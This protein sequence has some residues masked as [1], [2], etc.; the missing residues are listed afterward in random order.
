[1]AIK[2]YASRC[3]EL[4]VSGSIST[5][6]SYYPNQAHTTSITSLSLKGA[7]HTFS[8]QTAG[9]RQN[10]SRNNMPS[11]HPRIAIIGG[12]PAGLTLGGLLHRQKIPFT[13]YE[14]R[15]RP[16]EA[17]LSEPS[18]MLDLHEE[19]GLAAIRACGLYEQFL[20]YTADCEESTMI[21][22][23]AGRLLHEDKGDL[24]SRP[25]I[26]RNNISRLFLSVLPEEG[27]R[28]IRYGH[29]L[30]SAARDDATGEIALEFSNAD[31]NTVT[32]TCDLV[33]GAD[34]AWSRIRP[35]LTP[36][37][38]DLT[39][40]SYLQLYVKHI[41]A[42]HPAISERVG[43]GTMMALGN[44]HGLGTQRG[45]QDAMQMY[46][47]VNAA[48][49]GPQAIEALKGMSILEQK[50][51]L[52]GDAKF[53]GGYGEPMKELLRIAFDA[54]HAAKSGE[55][56][57]GG[58]LE[59]RPLVMLPVGHAWAH[60]SG[61]TLIGDAA[62]VMLPF[63]GEGVNLAM[64]D[65]LELSQAIVQAAASSQHKED[66]NAALGPLVQDFEREMFARAAQFSKESLD[67]MELHMAEDGAER[68]ATIMKTI[69]ESW[70][71]GPGSDGPPAS[72]SLVDMYEK[73][74][75]N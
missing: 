44:R 22:D 49:A 56:H 31:G 18:A 5:L 67:N 36:A 68:F 74:K 43:K 30:L 54:E 12:G 1:M 23:G 46:V 26:A 20:P 70:G 55:Q 8:I 28:A 51:R 69:Y 62:H 61:V 24:A 75:A 58:T 19:S 41:T 47:F 33:V 42:K 52:L 65:A 21:R 45:T 66:F 4:R 64:R 7:Y 14:L 2:A 39:E 53:F 10:L 29:K 59:V 73:V 13:I 35:L 3:L 38:P 16:T 32:E 72:M 50:E 63:A 27:G 37:R 57:H 17:D 15:P 40:L 11:T 6:P 60:K 9:A 25:E 34:G 71:Q 48:Q